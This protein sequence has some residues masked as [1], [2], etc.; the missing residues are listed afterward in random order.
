MTSNDSAS[1]EPSRQEKHGYWRS[2]SEYRGREEFDQYLHR[3]FPVDASELP[4]GV[5]RRRWIQLMGASLAMAGAAGCR[6]PEEIIAPFVVRP[7]GRIPGESYSRATNIQLAD[8][9]YNLLVTCVDG[10]P[11]KIEP[12][13]DH[14]GGSGTDAYVQASILGLYDPDRSRFDQG[15]VIRR[16]EKRPAPA[17]WDDFDSE[18]K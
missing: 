12:N 7:E 15:D 16:T 10:R 3:E 5:S 6:Y 14:P 11:L 8:K 1:T 17:S 9:V 4:E 2:L 13:N 18:A